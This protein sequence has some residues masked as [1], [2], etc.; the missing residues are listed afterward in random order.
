MPTKQQYVS[1]KSKREEDGISIRVARLVDGL[2]V[3]RAMYRYKQ[4][5]VA[6]HWLIPHTKI[7]IL[8]TASG[9][10]APH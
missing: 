7:R 1:D 5:K 8:P 3:S 9:V 4:G 6:S 10:L 2:H